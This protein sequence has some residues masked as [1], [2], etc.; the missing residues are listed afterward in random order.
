MSLDPAFIRAAHRLKLKT[1]RLDRRLGVGPSGSCSRPAARL[2]M[3]GPGPVVSWS[4]V[5]STSISARPKPGWAWRPARTLG[6]AGPGL[7]LLGPR[8][9]AG[10]SPSEL[11][12]RAAGGGRPPQFGGRTL[13]GGAGGH[14]RRMDDRAKHVTALGLRAGL[15]FGVCWF[16]S[17]AL[18]DRSAAT[19]LDLI[20][21]LATL[22]AIDRLI[23]RARTGSPDS[24]PPWPSWP[25]AGPPLVVIGWRSSSSA[26]RTA[27]FSLAL[28]CRRW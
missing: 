13:A 21:G 9:L 16:G 11:R 4:W 3:V 7:R 10:A 22:A 28:I 23:T 5:R 26:G 18:I 1:L 25:A 24:G 2:A 6:P 15:L 19:G 27:S 14:P 17:L 8:S 20:L 12:A